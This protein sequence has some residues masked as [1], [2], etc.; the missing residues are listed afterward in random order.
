MSKSIDQTTPPRRPTAS[1]IELLAFAQS[2]ELTAR[3]LYAQALAAGAGDD[4]VA[5][6][7][8]LT[9]H[10]DAYAQSLSAL[11]GTNAPQTRD[12]AL[13]TALKSGFGATTSTMALAAHGLEN[14]L[15]VTHSDLL[16]RLDGTEGAALVAAIVIGESRHCAA[17]AALAGKSPVDDIDLFITTSAVESLAPQA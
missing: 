6:I 13:F 1:D 12:E 4:H 5:S 2:A 17:M 15:V 3:D 10:H 7:A 14:T 16:G 8:A 9:A 11:L